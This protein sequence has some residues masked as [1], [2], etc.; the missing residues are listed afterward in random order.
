MWLL[1]IS[2][3]IIFV[4]SWKGIVK[5][6][7]F[8]VLLLLFLLKERVL[9]FISLFNELISVLLEL[10]WL[11]EVLV[12][13][14]FCCFVG[15]RLIWFVVLMI[16]WV[17]V[18]FRLYGLLIVSMML[19]ICGVCFVLI[20]MVGSLLVVLIFS[21]VRLV[22]ELELISSVLKMWLFCSVMIIWLVLLIMCLLVII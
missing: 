18:C 20:G 7:F 5:L 19:L 22:S 10:L 21:I 12:W 15:F 16:F 2:L 14:K 3:F 6:R 8:G 9:I 13:R 1:W 17:M 4:V 11:I